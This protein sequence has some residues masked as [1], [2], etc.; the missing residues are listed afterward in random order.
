MSVRRNKAR[1][2]ATAG[3]LTVWL[4]A[5][6][7]A[8]DGV[9][10]INQAKVKAGGG[11]FPFVITQPGSYRLTSNLDVTDATARASGVSAE[12]TTAISVPTGVDN[13]TIDLNGFAILGPCA[14]ASIG[15][16]SSPQGS[17]VGIDRRA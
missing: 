11:H 4:A 14:G 12:N 6:V 13:V 15:A 7:W 1:L 5:P 10:E 9:I 16:A 3:A 17:G 2:M 8:V